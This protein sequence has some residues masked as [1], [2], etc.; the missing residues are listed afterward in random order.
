MRLSVLFEQFRY[1]TKKIY[2]K[3]YI[4]TV[5][6]EKWQ[7]WKQI[8]RVVLYEIS[9]K[10][11]WH[12]RLWLF[13]FHRYGEKSCWYDVKS[14]GGGWYYFTFV[15]GRGWYYFTVVWGEGMVLLHR[16][17]GERDGITP[18]LSWG[19]G[20]ERGGRQAGWRATRKVALASLND[21]RFSD[22][23]IWCTGLIFFHSISALHM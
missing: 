22:Q 19:K 17:L 12:R 9:M 21:R 11:V 10:W 20:E 16:C 18:L 6:L 13:Y 8:L 15:W 14:Q 4:N 7:K 1:S 23:F 5:T 2:S 3:I